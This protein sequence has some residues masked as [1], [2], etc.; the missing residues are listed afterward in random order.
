M[1]FH[2]Q[3]SIPVISPVERCR[4]D[5]HTTAVIANI[6]GISYF[7]MVIGNKFR[8]SAIVM[9]VSISPSYICSAVFAGRMWIYT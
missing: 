3:Q 6:L 4:R 8:S 5:M 9:A 1:K 2:A 7:A